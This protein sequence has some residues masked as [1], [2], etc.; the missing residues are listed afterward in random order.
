MVVL[1]TSDGSS[2]VDSRGMRSMLPPSSVMK[3]TGQ[4]WT[5]NAEECV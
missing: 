4:K 5:F 2:V 3:K 1:A